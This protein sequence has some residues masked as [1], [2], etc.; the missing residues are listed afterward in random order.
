MGT[1][2]LGSTEMGQGRDKR[3]F[4]ASSVDLS[5]AMSKSLSQ[6]D[7]FEPI[8]GPMITHMQVHYAWYGILLLLAASFPTS[9]PWIRF[10]RLPI[11][12]IYF[13]V[14]A[15]VL[16]ASMFWHRRRPLSLLPLYLSNI[17]F[18]FFLMLSREVHVI[19]AMLW[20]ISI[21][22]ISMQ[23]GA[24]Q[25][26]LHTFISALI[27]L[28]VYYSGVSIMARCYGNAAGQLLIEFSALGSPVDIYSEV[29]F[30]LAV[31]VLQAG[32]YLLQRFIRRYAFYLLDR[33]RKM[34]KLTAANQELREKISTYKH[35]VDLDLDTPLTKV[36]R[37]IRQ[38]QAKNSGNEEIHESLDFVIG[39]L[40]SNQLFS[41]KFNAQMD[42]IDSEVKGWL[43]DLL[44]TNTTQA[45]ETTPQPNG[46]IFSQAASGKEG[47][48]GI[49][50]GLQHHG[51]GEHVHFTDGPG[52][53][54]HPNYSKII[55]SLKKSNS[56]D[57]NCFE[58]ADVTDGRP[59]FYFGYYMF[60]VHDFKNMFKI[61]DRKL[62][63]FFTKLEAGYRKNPYH[64]SIHA[65]DVAQS[66]N[67][68][69][70]ALG[71]NQMLTPEER[72]AM[73]LAACIHDVDHPAVSNSFLIDI[74]SDLS[75]RYNDQGVL[76]NHHCAKGL[77]WLIYDPECN[78]LADIESAPTRK[79]IRQSII[80]MVLATD[81]SGH[82]EYIS[83]LKNKL[84][85]SDF[86]VAVGINANDAGDRQL[87]MDV[88]VKCGDISNPAK[89]TA[90]SQKWTELVLAEFFL[91]G[92]EEKA[93]GMPVS[94]F[95]DRD[96][97][98]IGR[99]QNG[100]ID[101][102]VTPLYEVWDDF[103]RGRGHFPA[104][105][106]IHENRQLWTTYPDP[107]PGRVTTLTISPIPTPK[108]LVAYLNTP[109]VIRPVPA[110]FSDI[111]TMLRPSQLPPQWQS[112]PQGALDSTAQQHDPTDQSALPMS[113][114]STLKPKRKSFTP[115]DQSRSPPGDGVLADLANPSAASM[116]R[117]SRLPPIIKP[118]DR[119]PNQSQVP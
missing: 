94:K 77:E 52:K 119:A 116:A 66:C 18:F 112:Q 79:K 88:A 42:G 64:N 12:C 45:L 31:L 50:A 99:C 102:L 43:D 44:T 106:H 90:L 108:Y 53:M 56:W 59:L 37:I 113:K 83:R 13:G 36:I 19:F 26:S 107:P 85:S 30:F 72:L 96:A 92:D 40:S 63:S 21:T 80:K 97:V 101:Y 75:M 39:I 2:D 76:E 34:D 9:L 3:Q 23:T 71:L 48:A 67:Y 69:L 32:L 81:L 51:A 86:N 95:M 118:D 49:L 46:A 110:P 16:V 104:M 1:I 14:A 8:V 4:N 65:T 68:F 35:N 27:F 62:I 74:R 7:E 73:I 93:R 29:I 103:M 6:D 98:A 57:Y 10:M 100:F 117:K 89:D 55:E 91:Q 60:E 105:Q 24:K 54:I 25:L 61:D 28:T 114:S 41:V 38:I 15:V 11:I 47:D 5:P 20:F 70:T 115:S 87:V 109:L 58:L 17:P 33:R 78:I 84:G 22:T 82:F 111:P